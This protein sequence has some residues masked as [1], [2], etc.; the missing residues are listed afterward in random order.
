MN[1]KSI[2]YLTT[3]LAVISCLS[4][5]PK[6]AVAGTKVY[7]TSN[8]ED[9]ALF[10]HK[11]KS[12]GFDVFSEENY[13]YLSSDQKKQLKELKKCKDKGDTLSEEQQKTMHSIIICIL[14]GRLG[15]KKY[16]DYNGLMDKKRSNINLTEEENARLKE[17]N[18]IIDGSKPTGADILDQFLR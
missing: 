6:E 5:I 15:D 14:K 8:L 12:K 17:Y 16:E 2:Q 1:K 4:F 13:K 18:D 10:S 9:S 11:D 3:S 7:L